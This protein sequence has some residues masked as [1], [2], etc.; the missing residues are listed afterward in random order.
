MNKNKRALLVPEALINR[1]EVLRFRL[2]GSQ[3][4]GARIPSAQSLLR[5]LIDDALRAKGV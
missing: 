3:G 1:A 2:I 4:G 5:D